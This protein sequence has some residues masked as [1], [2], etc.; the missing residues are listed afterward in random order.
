[1]AR[2]ESGEKKTLAVLE[3][4]GAE[5]ER[6]QAEHVEKYRQ[7]ENDLQQLAAEH[8]AESEQIKF[9]LQ[10]QVTVDFNKPAYLD[11]SA[12]LLILLSIWN[13]VGVFSAIGCLL[14]WDLPCGILYRTGLVLVEH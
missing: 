7:L 11:S 4:H 14:V 2:L 6:I 3:K 10:R 12:F 13:G 8:D 5:L 1:M 9:E